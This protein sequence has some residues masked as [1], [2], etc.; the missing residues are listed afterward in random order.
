MGFFYDI[1]FQFHLLGHTQTVFKTQGSILM[2]H[3]T[4]KRAPKIKIKIKVPT[5]DKE[6]KAARLHPARFK[7]CSLIPNQN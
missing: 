3:M 5:K 1:Y 4:P 7:L 2:Q 6:I